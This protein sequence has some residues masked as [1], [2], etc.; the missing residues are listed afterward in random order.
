MFNQLIQTDPD[1]TLLF[2]RVVAG[3]IIFPY[4]MQKLFGWFPEFG[5]GVGPTETLARMSEKKIPKPLAWLIILGQSI[6]SIVLIIGLLGR[7]AAGANFIIFTGAMITHLPDGWVINWMGKKKGE[8]IEYFILLLS[9][10]LVIAI[11]GSGPL[12]V[13]VWLASKLTKT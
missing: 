8:G 3:V 4:G 2:I 11:R 1:Y 10:L 6:G 7:I 12:S 9:L 5:G 13:D